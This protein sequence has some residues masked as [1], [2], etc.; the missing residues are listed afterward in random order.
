MTNEQHTSEADA[1]V[2]TTSTADTETTTE[3][4]TGTDHVHTRTSGRIHHESVVDALRIL[5]GSQLNTPSGTVIQLSSINELDAVAYDTAVDVTTVNPYESNNVIITGT[6]Q[7][8]MKAGKEADVEFVSRVT[9]QTPYDARTVFQTIHDDNTIAAE[10]VDGLLTRWTVK[11]TH[12]DYAISELLNNGFNVNIRPDTLKS[13]YNPHPEHTIADGEYI[14]TDDALVDPDYYETNSD[15][16]GASTTG[17]G[18]GGNPHDALYFLEHGECPADECESH[19]E[20][21][22]QLRGHI[23]GSVAG[24]SGTGPHS[25]VNLRLNDIDIQTE[26]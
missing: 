9:F 26:K 20:T 25:R 1:R 14:I 16:D 7:L 8:A 15:A 18:N 21:F 13:L 3:P 4:T 19:F 22:R 2:P 23:G 10:F 5:A 24:E 17:H 6:Q 11:E 12:V